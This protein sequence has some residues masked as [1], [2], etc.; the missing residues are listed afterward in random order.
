LGTGLG[1]GLALWLILAASCLTWFS[2]TARANPVEKDIRLCQA[3]KGIPPANRPEKSQNTGQS[4]GQS[5]GQPTSQ[6]KG[7]PPGMVAMGGGRF[8][9]G[10]ERFYPE[11]RP[12]RAVE[13][14]P[15][16]IQRHEVTN[17]QFAAFVQSTGYRTVAERPLD[18]KQFSQ[19]SEAQRRAGSL[20]FHKPAQ[21]K[22]MADISQWWTWTPGASWRAPEGPGS[23]L[24][25]RANHPVVHIAFEDAMAYAQWAG[26][27]LPTEAEWEFAAKG[28]LED[29]DYTWGNDKNRRDAKGKPMANHWQGPFPLQDLKE[30]GHHGTA[31]VGC[32]PANGYGLFDMAGNA[33]ELTQ[34]DYIDPRSPFGGMKV[35]KGGSFLC[36]DDYCGRYRPAARS[37]H[38]IDTGMQHVGF[39]TVWRGK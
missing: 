18:A 32:F 3:Y 36:S 20:V 25:G 31:P 17:A 4:T 28:G 6:D 39:R 34:D 38:G 21:V 13:V 16:Y 30:D 5:K 7:V 24:R 8:M 2:P 35:A 11:E 23:H 15:F 22:G 26:Q 33:W 27:D 14:A 1:T 19:L 12:R 10:S 37:P 9:M 29:A